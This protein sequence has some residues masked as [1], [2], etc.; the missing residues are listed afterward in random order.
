MTR[1]Y[2][3]ATSN[4]KGYGRELAPME[5]IQK[6]NLWRR[7][8]PIVESVLEQDF[9]NWPEAVFSL[10]GKDAELFFEV[11]SLVDASRHL[12]GFIEEPVDVLS[13]R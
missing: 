9:D 4:T 2:S 10:C 12:D 6:Q 8:Q 7:A 5:Q 13:M 1:S 3:E 11:T